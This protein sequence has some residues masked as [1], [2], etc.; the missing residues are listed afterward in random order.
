MSYGNLTYTSNG[1]NSTCLAGVTIYKPDGSW[2]IISGNLFPTE[3]YLS[4]TGTYKI[5]IDPTNTCTLTTN[6]TLNPPTGTI[7][8]DGAAVVATSPSAGQTVI[9][10]FTGTAGQ[11]ISLGATNVSTTPA[12]AGVISFT[13]LDSRGAY[14]SNANTSGTGATLTTAALSTTGTYYLV[15]KSPSSATATATLTLSNDITGTVT[16]NGTP[17]PLTIGRIGQ[18]ARFT[19]SATAGESLEL[20]LSN[21][22][23]VANG[24]TSTCSAE[25]IVYKPDNTFLIWTRVYEPGDALSLTN[26]PLTGGYQILIDPTDSCTMTTNLNLKP[27][28]NTLATNGVAVVAT[29][30][31]PNQTIRYSFVGT[32][33]QYITLGATNVSTT[34]ANAGTVTFRILGTDG[35]AVL[36][37]GTVT[38]SGGTA[39]N[40][41]PLATTGIYFV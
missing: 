6:I 12:N 15:M 33:G 32:A 17:L 14:V 18:N 11:Y 1:Y 30:P 4:A 2:W 20:N 19:F 39:L 3:L 25:V 41:S 8:V 34:P 24:Y 29:N 21:V 37:S 26:L 9:Y 28:A 23:Y 5:F 16:T 38:N 35:N 36:S 40:T 10:S 7:T 27:P 31:T 13:L 22:A